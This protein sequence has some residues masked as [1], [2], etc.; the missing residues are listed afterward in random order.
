MVKQQM[1]W[2]MRN[3]QVKIKDGGVKSKMDIY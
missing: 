3:F 1:K 2:F